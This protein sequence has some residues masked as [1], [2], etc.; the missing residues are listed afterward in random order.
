MREGMNGKQVMN[1]IAKQL[2]DIKMEQTRSTRKLDHVE[3]KTLV[4]NK[5]IVNLAKIT[6]NRVD[7][8]EAENVRLKKRLNKV[9]SICE[10]LQ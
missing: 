8:L 5:R 2:S 9:E 3:G 4:N 1:Y 6:Q 10:K 7:Y